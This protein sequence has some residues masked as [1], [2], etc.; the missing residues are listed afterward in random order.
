[1]KKSDLKTGMIITMR[2]GKEYMVYKDVDT[3]WT[4]GDILF[5]CDGRHDWVSLDDYNEDM[6]TYNSEWD[7]VKVT[8][9]SHPF[10]IF[11]E[12]YPDVTREIIFEVNPHQ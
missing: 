12:K 3:G 9:I 11:Q 8:K 4:T 2:D 6:T 10:G 5:A 1:M 7:I